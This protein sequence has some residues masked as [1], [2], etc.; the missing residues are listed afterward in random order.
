[1]S[2]PSLFQFIAETTNAAGVRCVLIGGFAVNYYKVTRQ[3][4]DVDFLITR[5][6]FD[7]IRGALEK[8]GFTLEACEDVFARLTGGKSYVMD[9]DFLFVDEAT[10]DKV[11][12]GGREVAIGGQAFIIPSLETVIALKLHAIKNNVSAR[13]FRD[14]PDVINL[15]RANKID[16]AS[17]AFRELCLKYGSE[18]LYQKIQEGLR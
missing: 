3:T 18:E 2:H 5:E 11:I 13:M 10:L 16:H 12:A 17:K 6:G 1:M 14:L 7:R 15:I 4:V 8:G 9:L